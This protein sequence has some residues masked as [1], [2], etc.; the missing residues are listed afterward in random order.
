M[1]FSSRKKLIIIGLAGIVVLTLVGIVG[2]LSGWFG[3]GTSGFSSTLLPE[4]KYRRP[5]TLSGQTSNLTD[6]QVKIE[7]SASITSALVTANKLQSDFDDIRFTDGNDNQLLNFWIETATTTATSTIWVKVPGLSAS[8]SSTIYMYYGNASAAAASNGSAIY[9]FYENF[10]GL[11]T[12]T[13][14]GQG[15]WTKTVGPD[16]NVQIINTDR[17]EGSKSAQIIYASA[18]TDVGIE[19]SLPTQLLSGRL[20]VWV[21]PSS[22][23]FDWIDVREGSGTVNRRIAIQF[24]QGSLSNIYYENTSG[25]WI[26]TGVA[27]STTNWKKFE[28]VWNGDADTFDVYYDGA[29]IVSNIASKTITSGINYVAAYGSAP[30]STML[31]DSLFIISGYVSP[32]P[33]A[34]V[35][36]EQTQMTPVAHWRFDE[37]TGTTT[38]DS[39]PNNKDGT[40]SGAQWTT[41]KFNTGLKFDGIDDYV[42]LG[43][44]NF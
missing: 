40:I 43:D 11:N 1:K 37:G 9:S 21:K 32:E 19:K 18:G 31:L 16:D 10:E 22:N 28:I 5:I 8:K 24:G 25:I 2:A 27:Y 41:G 4:W 13:W 42:N 34:T 36:D 20:N 29:R 12:G 6:Y 44:I 35:G 30:H 26:D 14:N 7:L 33:T 39:T 15:G 17:F 38:Y 3:K 23:S